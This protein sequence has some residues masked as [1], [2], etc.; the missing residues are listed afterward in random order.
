MTPQ[1]IR[2][3]CYSIPEIEEDIEVA[4]MQK[5]HLLAATSARDTDFCINV[6]DVYKKLG[7]I[8]PIINRKDN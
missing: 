3:L 4:G 2:S 5:L 7:L 6:K 1:E 8:M